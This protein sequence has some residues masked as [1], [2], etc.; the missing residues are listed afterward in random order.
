V[1]VDALPYYDQGYDESGVREAALALV[2]EETKRYRPTKNYLDNLG[3]ARYDAFETEIMKTELERLQARLPMD[4]LSM[5]RYELP[6]PSAGRMTDVAAWQESVDN[7]HAQLSHQALRI[8]NLE[9]MSQYGSDAWKVSNSVL[10]QMLDAAR[11]QLVDL[12]KQ[13]QEINWQRKNEQTSAG[14][15]LR[16]LEESWVGLVSKNYEIER[17]CM[18]LEA[19]VQELE[20]KSKKL[21]K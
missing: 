14:A 6:Q 8:M 19:E 3:P 10:Q 11:K 7:S 16:Q 9:L 13:I 2:E 20:H 17:A 5:K 15:K 12:R 21:K 1:Y 18:E 4:M